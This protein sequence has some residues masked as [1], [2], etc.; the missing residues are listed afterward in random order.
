M[1]NTDLRSIKK[2]IVITAATRSGSFLL[3]NL[4]DGHPHIITHP[5]HTLGDLGNYI[6]TI[7]K[8]YTRFIK[9]V[10]K[11]QQPLSNEQLK[12]LLMRQTI[13][14]SPS[15]SISLQ[16][17]KIK[18]DEFVTNLMSTM[19]NLFTDHATNPDPEVQRI[20]NMIP[21]PFEYIKSTKVQG[22][23]REEFHLAAITLLEQHFL[24]YDYLL[25]TDVFALI[26]FAYEMVV[27]KK[28][29]INSPVIVWQKHL[30]FQRNSQVPEATQSELIES[31]ARNAIYI[32]T[33]R[34]PDEGINSWVTN[35]ANVGHG[36]SSV[37]ESYKF[38]ICHFVNSIT[39]QALNGPQYVVRFEDM[40]KNTKALTEKLCEISEIPWH[41]ILLETTLDGQEVGF[42]KRK[43]KIKTGMVTGVNKNL[44]PSNDYK[45]LTQEDVRQITMLFHNAYKLYNYD[46]N[47]STDGPSKG[48]YLFNLSDL[49]Y[50]QETMKK[51]KLINLLNIRE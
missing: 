28:N 39:A 50:E 25:S 48:K 5:P 37:E 41:P 44:N 27:N 42:L 49:D 23:N 35:Q 18:Y 1:C 6:S 8:F 2:T 40:H 21:E 12:H 24:N 16:L 29:I 9:F 43:H 38:F 45:H 36:F 30:F 22:A 20:R 3:H 33:V 15:Y 51:N 4:L 17:P 26:F 10:N 34:R 46:I 13:N 31:V 32:T 19:P 11:A 7:F 47:K 14:L